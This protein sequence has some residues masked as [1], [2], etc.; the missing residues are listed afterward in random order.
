MILQR[1]KQ[2][3]DNKKIPVSVFEKSIGMSNASFGKSLKN[4]GTIGAD[5]LEI[6]LNTY[7]D[8][9]IEWLILGKGEMLKSDTSNSKQDLGIYKE[10]HEK[11]KEEIKELNREIGKL[12]QTVEQLKKGDKAASWSLA[13]EPKLEYKGKK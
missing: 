12:Q 8:I 2:Y 1:I 9:N 3:I 6:I 5:K 11:Q 7:T 10:L 13:A 4:G